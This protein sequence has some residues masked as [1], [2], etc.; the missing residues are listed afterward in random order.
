[1]LLKTLFWGCKNGTDV[2]QYPYATTQATLTQFEDFREEYNI[3]KRLKK[4]TM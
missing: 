4:G 1:M 2:I 3:A